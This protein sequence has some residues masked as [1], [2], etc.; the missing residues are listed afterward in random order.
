MKQRALCRDSRGLAPARKCTKYRRDDTRTSPTLE[1]NI[2]SDLSSLLVELRGKESLLPQDRFKYEYLE[3]EIFSKYLNP[4][5]SRGA[6]ERKTAAIEKWRAAELRNAKTNSRLLIDTAYFR[7]PKGAVSSDQILTFARGTIERVLGES[8]SLEVLYGTFTGGASTLFRRVP[9]GTA[10]KFMDEA[11]VTPSALKWFKLARAY[12]QGWSVVSDQ[13]RGSSL[14]VEL[15]RGNVMFTVPKTSVI[16]RCACKEPGLNMFLQKGVGAFIRRRLRSV[17]RQDLNDQ[18][19]NQRLARVGSMDG[20]LATIDLSSASDTISTQLIYRLLPLDWFC[21]L[22]DIRSK[23][24]SVDGEEVELH[25]FSSMGNAFTF[26][27]ETLVFWSLVNAIC[28]YAGIKG[29]ISVYGDDII[30]P[31][32]CAALVAQVF[33]FMG[34]L[35]NPKKSHWSGPFRES[36]GKH[37]YAG[38]D[39]TPF[40]IRE[41][42]N[43][44]PRLLHFLN[45]L[46]YWAGQGRPYP[47]DLF[48]PL[49]RKYKEQVPRRYRGGGDFQSIYQL[50]TYETPISRLIPETKVVRDLS[51]AGS[52][53]LWLRAAEGRN[54]PCLQVFRTE[55]HKLLPVVT[56]PLVTS[57]VLE[58]KRTYRTIPADA[59]S[60]GMEQLPFLGELLDCLSSNHG[61]SPT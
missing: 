9:G 13:V 3:R 2:R 56:D 16:D 35:V 31:S 36:C 1:E 55:K 6:R 18:T 10:Q 47:C 25:M 30:C 60:T 44:L 34:F 7:F 21:Y 5:L 28:F 45:R 33:S 20:S 8:P 51:S 59:Y 54:T 42:V 23:Y 40:Y 12:N 50:V 37:W 14:E 17:L 48:Y 49:W 43:N 26:E 27:L 58:V 15:V 61:A 46:K 22:D 32:K 41:P 57:S 52:Y 53:L 38:I 4:S 19:H 39:V 29:T 24:C 11:H